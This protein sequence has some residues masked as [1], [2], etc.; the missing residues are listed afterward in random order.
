VQALVRSKAVD[1]SFA[2]DS[3]AIGRRLA[4]TEAA[5]KAYHYK[6]RDALHVLL[7][8]RSGDGGSGSQVGITHGAAG[9]VAVNKALGSQIGFH[10]CVG[11]CLTPSMPMLCI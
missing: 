7:D 5:L 11:T 1:L 3:E 2:A 8:G 9:G 4:E 10:P 6:Y